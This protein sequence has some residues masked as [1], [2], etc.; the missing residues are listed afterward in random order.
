MIHIRIRTR[1]RTM[2]FLFAKNII[3]TDCILVRTTCSPSFSVTEHRPSHGFK[4]TEHQLVLTSYT[5]M[6]EASLDQIMNQDEAQLF[7]YQC[8]RRYLQEEAERLDRRGAPK[9]N[10]LPRFKSPL[11]LSPPPLNRHLQR[12]EQ[13]QRP[14]QDEQREH[15]ARNL[16]HP[17]PR[18]SDRDRIACL[19]NQGAE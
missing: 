2:V 3:L 1:I 18:R 8:E 11:L 6:A 4:T 13:Q 5:A 19:S 12:I 9:W 16:L 14:R 7:V 15:E 10:D 17:S